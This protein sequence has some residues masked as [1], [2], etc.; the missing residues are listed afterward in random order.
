VIVAVSVKGL[1]PNGF[2][3]VSVEVIVTSESLE[4]VRVATAKIVSANLRICPGQ[5]L[6]AHDKPKGGNPIEGS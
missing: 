5:V 2:V 4:V 6:A 3:N 1:V